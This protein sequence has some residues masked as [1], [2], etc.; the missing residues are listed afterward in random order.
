MR[1]G[2]DITSAVTQ[3]AGIGRYTREL[4]RALFALDAG[5]RPYR[6][7]LF[8]ASERP[9][10]QPIGPL[11]PNARLRRLPFHDKWLARVWHRFQIPLPV[12]LVTGRVDLFHSPDFTLPPT[13]ASIPT[14]LTVHD[15]S[16]IRDPDSALPALRRFLNRA[17]PRSVARARRV[18][19]DSRSEER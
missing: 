18:L 8:Y 10:D 13:L 3:S 14:L 12:E 7:S 19:A 1:I 15:L 2:I 9:V 6:Y 16:F 5:A 11:P 4:V 17:V